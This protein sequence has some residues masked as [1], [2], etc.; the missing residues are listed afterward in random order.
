MVLGL[1]E[2]LCVSG[3]TRSHIKLGT[4]SSGRQIMALA[5]RVSPELFSPLKK[6]TPCL[7]CADSC[8]SIVN[9]KD[10]LETR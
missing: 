5:V 4:R 10:G 3:S 1:D 2:E 9:R 6:G 7:V 8:I